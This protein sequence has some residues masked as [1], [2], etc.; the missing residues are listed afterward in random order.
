[1]SLMKVNVIPFKGYD[2]VCYYSIN[3]IV[4]N[5]RLSKHDLDAM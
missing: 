3:C 1:M 2:I 4:C 5:I